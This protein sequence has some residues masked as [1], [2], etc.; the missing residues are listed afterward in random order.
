MRSIPREVSYV[1][2]QFDTSFS[3]LLTFLALITVEDD[4]NTRTNPILK[5]IGGRTLSF[6]SGINLC[7]NRYASLIIT[8]IDDFSI[9]NIP[10]LVKSNYEFPLERTFYL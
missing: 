7:G 5:V 8:I 1:S 9:Y 3:D 10:Y 2:H 6:G 4:E